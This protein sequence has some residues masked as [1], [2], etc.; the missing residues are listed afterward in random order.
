MPA[1]TQIR[2]ARLD[3]A[4]SLTELTM[5]SKA[6]WQYAAAFLADARQEREFQPNKFLP[7]FHVYIL[8]RVG[9]VL[10]FCSL[11]PIGN[12]SI[13]L[14]D[15]FVE[16]SYIG[17]GYGKQLWDHSVSLVREL[18]FRTLVLTADPNAEPF[19]ARQGAV[20]TGER[21]SS[22]RSDRKLPIMEYRISDKA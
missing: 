15:L 2:R 20:R 4:P 3:E 17:K 12:D 6:Y 8:E 19:Y 21:E 14:H 11:I 9:Q 1:K 22:V 18:G 7:D 10:G 5:R 16:P 13:E